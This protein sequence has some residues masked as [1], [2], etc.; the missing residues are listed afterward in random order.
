M[1]VGVDGDTPVARASPWAARTDASGPKELLGPR[2]DPVRYPTHGTKHLRYFGTRPLGPTPEAKS[3]YLFDATWLSLFC[4]HKITPSQVFTRTSC[5]LT[6]DRS[7]STSG[8]PTVQNRCVMKLKG[9]ILVVVLTVV[10]FT[11]GEAARIVFPQAAVG[12]LEDEEFQIELYLA[13]R[14]PNVPWEGTLWFLKGLDLTPATGVTVRIPGRNAQDMGD[15]LA[16]QLPPG[17]STSYYLSSSQ[18]TVGV[19]VIESETAAP[20]NL[21][22]S[23]FYRLVSHGQGKDLIAVQPSRSPSLAYSTTLTRRN[24]LDVGL[25][26]V[27]D[28]AVTR[29][30]RGLSI[31]STDVTLTFTPP[32]GEPQVKVVQLNET[33][34][35]HQA[36]F[37]FE[38]FEEGIPSDIG[39][40]RLD[41]HATRPIH[42]T[43][44]A[45]GTE[46]LFEDVQLGATPA[47]S[48]AWEL[49]Q[50]PPGTA[51]PSGGDNLLVGRFW[52]CSS[53][54]LTEYRGG[55]VVATSES[56]ATIIHQQGPSLRVGGD[57]TVAASIGLEQGQE[58]SI[59]LLGRLPSGT[60]WYQGV[61]RLDVGVNRSGN[62]TATAF[63]DGYLPVFQQSF[64]LDPPLKSKTNLVVRRDDDGFDILADGREVGRVDDTVQLFE[65]GKLYFGLNVPR[66]SRLALYGLAAFAPE[67]QALQVA[68]SPFREVQET[69]QSSLRTAAA[70]RGFR[71]GAAAVPDYIAQEEAYRRTL[72]SQFNLLTPENVMKFGPIHPEPDRFDFC[73][74][75]ALVEFAEANNMDVRGHTLVWH[76]QLPSWVTN[77][78]YTK[79]ELLAILR[80]HIQ[81][82]VGR[83]RGRIQH[84]DVVN[85]AIDDSEE[86]PLRETVWLNTIGSE[87]LEWAFRWAHEADPAAKLYYN[88]YGIE[89][90]N[91]KADAVYDLVGD[92]VNKQVPIHGVGF[93]FHVSLSAPSK[94][95]MKRNFERFTKLG[96]E[97]AVT[98]LDVSL[99]VRSGPPSQEALERQAEVYRRVLEACLETEGC[100]TFVTWG[101]TD[102]HSWIPGFSDGKNG[103]A[104]IFDEDYEP[105]PAYIALLKAL[106]GP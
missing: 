25:A 22:A 7:E 91:A 9:L 64:I 55:V 97:V 88:D 6:C 31:P 90:S 67:G 102:R 30:I 72:G 71:I 37:P 104:L 101:F 35:F 47:E 51:F 75:D 70:A 14:D 85:E 80:K 93:Q 41:I 52:P 43:L 54:L 18:L 44:L 99:D 34:G 73:P 100:N 95:E 53:S 106:T 79:E 69:A 103:A 68:P 105:K 42:V 19:L 10:S 33:N 39:S 60:A 32:S 13:N 59:M 29:A 26:L 78:D 84:W 92:L 65:D 76:Q 36:A 57:F 20:E 24:G 89:R 11:S 48:A 66:Q 21:V 62:V 15:N 12:L 8:N 94:E 28:E 23:F 16:V 49:F 1:P 96:L 40:A 3:D 77:T 74:A 58:G 5:S 87:Y 86:H 83:Y 81:T 98:E 2:G 50:L 82:V 46:P 17:G 61:R 4:L 56:A 38:L 27:A 45:V 63:N